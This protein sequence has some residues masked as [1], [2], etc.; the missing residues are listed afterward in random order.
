M[1]TAEKVAET[2]CSKKGLSPEVIMLLLNCSILIAAGFHFG[3]DQAVYSVTA[4][5][6]AYESVKLPLRGFRFTLSVS[7]KSH[8]CARIQEALAVYLNRNVAILES[9]DSQSGYLGV[10]E[11][12][13]HR[14]E[15]SRLIAVIKNCDPDSE[16]SFDV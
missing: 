7:I 11:C 15:A 13:C 12:K 5:I 1:D 2:F 6:L 8:E 10:M 9:P 3:F 14:W 16:I 4:Y